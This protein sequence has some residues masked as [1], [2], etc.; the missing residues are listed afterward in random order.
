MATH[1]NCWHCGTPDAG[2]IFCRY[3]NSLQAPVPNYFEFFGL[4]LNLSIDL[5]KLQKQFYQLSGLLH[6]DRYTRRSEQEKR[7]SLEASSILNDAYRVLRD[8]IQRA[9]YVLKEAGFDIGEQ[10]SKDVPPELL[11][12]VFELNMALDELRNGDDDVLPQLDESRKKFVDI[13]VDMDTG[14]EAEFK[15]HDAQTGDEA[16]RGV[17]A[18]IRSTLNRRRYIKNLVN[19]VDKLLTARN[20]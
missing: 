5:S 18:E 11:E 6:P 9:E 17:L 13:L 10:R 4:P 12:E 1:H 19:E 20:A 3:C 15:K 2:S 16:R 8:P 14:L 7:Y